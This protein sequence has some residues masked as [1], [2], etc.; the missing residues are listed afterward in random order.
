M[1]KAEFKE[2]LKEEKT[3]YLSDEQSQIKQMKR[4]C[5]M[6]YVIWRYLYYFRC[7]QY[8]SELRRSSDAGKLVRRIAKYKFRFYEKKKNQYSLKSGVE[9][10]INCEIGRNC[11]IWHSGVVINGA[12]GN[13]C[14]F[15][16]NNIIGNKGNARDDES[17]VLGNGVDVG[18][19]AV[20]IGDVRI[21][22]N[23]FVGAGAVVTKSFEEEGS[24]IVGVPGK[25]LN[26]SR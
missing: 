9:I 1:T 23:S 7:C 5:H 26:I 18:A 2:I 4:I 3:L 12:V 10:G 8:F 13:N 20:I 17:P 21:A 24:V 14:I 22:D 11:N 15:H 6:R 19:G 25:L 16:G